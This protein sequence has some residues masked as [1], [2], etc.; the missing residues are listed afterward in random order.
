[1]IFNPFKAAKLKQEAEKNSWLT[2]WVQS[3]LNDPTISFRGKIQLLS[4]YYDVLA[5]AK[6]TKGILEGSK[7]E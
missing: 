3:C 2:K 4:G 7:D 1:M 5:A 6:P